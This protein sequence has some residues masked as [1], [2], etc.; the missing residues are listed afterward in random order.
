MEQIKVDV[1]Y[2]RANVKLCGFSAGVAYGQLGPTHHSIEDLAWTRAIP[3]LTTV[4]PADWT[5]TYQAVTAVAAFEGPIYLRLSRI[6]VPDIP[7]RSVFEIGKATRLR[8]GSDVSIV[9]NGVMV[10]RALEAADV[11]Q[12]NGI[13]ARVINIATLKPI[14]GD[15]IIAAARETG[16]IVTIEESVTHGGLGAAVAEICAEKAP[17]RM[18]ILGVPDCFAPSDSPN[19]IFDGLQLNVKGIVAAASALVAD[20]ARAS[21]RISCNGQPSAPSRMEERGAAVM[22][23]SNQSSE[24]L[25]FVVSGPGGTGKSTL[26]R[27]WRKCEPSL[28][29]VPNVTTRK[30]R[31]ASQIDET[32]LYSFA[33]VDQFRRMVEADE[34]VQWV[35]PSAGKYY[36][37]PRAPVEVAIQNGVDLVFDFTPQLFLNFRQAYRDRI[38]SIFLGPPSLEELRSRLEARAT[39]TGQELEI[40]FMMGLQD[41]GYVDE[42]DYYVVNDDPQVAL[43]ELRAIRAAEHAKMARAPHVA[44]NYRRQAHRTMLVYYDPFNERV[45][46]IGR[47]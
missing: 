35:N 27:E 44:E 1:A 38:V 20:K 17:T 4:V 5:E 16:A 6:G 26:I 32:G 3:G 23:R 33:T 25:F 18:R 11:L 9:A 30:P 41:I 13:S 24:S 40:K 37:T 46:S 31:P 22:R 47:E 21:R 39:E 7:G 14:D 28:Q 19:A 10:A 12:T 34:F 45:T 2:S 8:D 36:G 43:A 29:Y 42:H 15:E